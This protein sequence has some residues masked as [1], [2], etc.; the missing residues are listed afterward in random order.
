MKHVYFLAAS[1]AGS[2]LT[3][4][5]LGVFR[6]LDRRG[7]RVGFAKPI[8]QEILG[9]E[10]QDAS[11]SLI[12]CTTGFEPADPLPLEEAETYV[13]ENNV[14]DLLE[15]VVERVSSQADEVDVMVVEGLLPTKDQTFQT[16]INA[17][18]AQALGADVILVN[19]MSS[20]E[21]AA[22]SD[23]L[24]TAAAIYGGWTHPRVFGCI[25]N[26]VRGTSTHEEL[27]LLAEKL[28]RECEIF[29]G[30]SFHLLGCVPWNFD[31][32]S[33][34]VSDVARHLNAHAKC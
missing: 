26:K 7:I 10:E 22:L 13:R 1:S 16:Q 3:S 24:E 9:Q 5:A 2:G 25:L 27:L 21:P 11:I 20:V 17:A 28:E 14:D 6:A 18:M 33:H 31:L 32:P 19:S 15:L 12:R 4:V 8:G 30:D 23:D 34:R 29:Q